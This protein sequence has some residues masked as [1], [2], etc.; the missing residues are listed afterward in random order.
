MKPENAL[1]PSLRAITKE[2]E[3]VKLF[4]DFGAACSLALRRGDLGT[5]FLS[6]VTATL[7]ACKWLPSALKQSTKENP[8]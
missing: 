5:A 6:F 3:A 2:P 7:A 4:K 8:Q 1:I